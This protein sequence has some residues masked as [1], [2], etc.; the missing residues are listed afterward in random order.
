[1][2]SVSDAMLKVIQRCDICIDNNVISKELLLQSF[3][4]FLSATIEKDK[5][6]FGLVLHTGS[7]CFDAI[8]LAYAALS[9]ILYNDINP[10]EI[11]HSLHKGDMVLYKKQRCVF[12]GFLEDTKGRLSSLPTVD[13]GD[14]ILLK[15]DAGYTAVDRLSW[16]K[17][18]PYMGASKK[19]DGRGLRKDTGKR[20]YFFNTVLGMTDSDIPG[21]IDASTVI[22]MPRDESDD[23]IKGLSFKYAQGEIRYTDLVT[24]SYFTEGNQ[25]YPY[26]RNA[27]K[28]EPVIKVTSKIAVARKLLFDKNGW[29]RNIGLIV[30]GE[31]SIQKGQT[32]LPELIERQ[33][34]QYVYLCT[35]IDSESS[36]SLL[37]NYPK[38]SLFACTGDFLLK[39]SGEVYKHNKYTKQLKSQVNAIIDH[40]VIP[41][42]L[43]KVIGWETY[44]S[45]KRAVYS[46]KTSD[47]DSEEKNNF[48]IQSYSLM[49][50]FMRA[51]FSMEK[52]EDAITAGTVR[53]VESPS[54]KMKHLESIVS[55]FPAYLSVH[56]KKVM[57]ILS[58]AYL[59]VYRGNKKAEYLKEKIFCSFGQK[60]CVVV[61][62]AYYIIVLK[63]M[64]AKF[65]NVS[66]VTANKF[67]NKELY[68]V[69][70]CVGNFNGR[71][72]DIFRC[73][74]SE[75]L[76]VML[77]EAEQVQ[78]QRKS[79]DSERA[80]FNLNSRSTFRVYD[81]K[82]AMKPEPDE[83]STIDEMEAIDN[84]VEDFIGTAAARTARSY[85][86][87]SGKGGT[88]DIV[89][90]AKFESEEVAFFTKNFKAYVLDEA[91][92]TAREA[93]VEEL[94]EGD[95]IIFTR[96]TAKTR[97]I[98]D[99]ILQEMIEKK[100]ISSQL[101]E[102]Y[103]KSKAWKSIL[104]EY[105]NIHN[106]SA[107]YIADA[108]IENGTTV[109]EATIRRWLDEDAH[110]V[111]PR[112]VDSL[113][114]IGDVTKNDDLKR[115]ANDYHSA[116]AEVRKVRRKILD[117]IGTATLTKV[118]GKQLKTDSILAT[119]NEEIGE[120]A[121]V[122]QID[123][124]AFVNETVPLHMINRPVSID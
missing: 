59:K 32:E 49:N 104:I 108:M 62:N 89:A 80:E 116:C 65:G 91:G 7:K 57:E 121:V 26:G 44:L 102:A 20:K 117:A 4:S 90:I 94:A 3:S 1:M 122:L 114:Q 60:M 98:V 73:K 96:S 107:K 31:E 33:S 50:L 12:Q 5:H 61:P 10:E 109:G 99:E 64:Y 37:E 115:H 82:N 28:T 23:L 16:G 18:T 83:Y 9:D 77:Y 52:L 81:K 69:I 53:N 38:A 58:S 17:I 29:N 120:M 85:F 56:A 67:N 97:D 84:E 88:A 86:N 93:K 51:P 39:Y 42:D 54:E 2:N 8:V 106:F 78:Y 110:I 123:S 119:V 92:A 27:A 63:E 14:F 70:I 113:R 45:F 74:S 103:H 105:M 75:K 22:V 43:K 13:D 95:T 19:L 124:I 79:R 6:N 55:G 11:L 100:R 118:T 87:G 71:K 101:T 40:V 36:E 48:V 112:D 35:H 46:I 30:L 47:Y 111:G 41:V 68:D 34:I 76:L 21:L 72:F 24:A 66:F 25:E 15:Q